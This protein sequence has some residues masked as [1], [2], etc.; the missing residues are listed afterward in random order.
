MIHRLALFMLISCLFLTSCSAD[1]ANAQDDYP[2]MK[3][4]TL[5]VL[6]TEE[7]K[8]VLLDLFSESEFQQRM[9]I[10][11]GNLPQLLG[12]SL[13]DQQTQKDWQKILS[14]EQVA[15][16]MHKV[17]EAEQKKL[18][19]TLMKDPEYQKMMLD[20]LKDPQFSQQ[21]VE[22]MKTPTY[23]KEA[24]KIMEEGLQTPSF[25]EKAKKLLQQQGKKSQGGQQQSSSGQES[26]SSG[27]S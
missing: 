26:G 1:G 2:K 13:H 6:H 7:G 24:L 19:K 11:N 12:K 15:K 20:I 10:A 25:Q 9:L 5:D 18:L 27:S 3:A 4:I 14:T 21:M 17:T 22:L 16:Q 23:R 8:K